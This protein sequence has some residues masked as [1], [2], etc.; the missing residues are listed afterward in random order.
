MLYNSWKIQE[1]FSYTAWTSVLFLV[2]FIFPK[3]LFVIQKGELRHHHLT[4]RIYP[5]HSSCSIWFA[6]Y[7]GWPCPSHLFFL[8]FK[9]IPL[10][11]PRPSSPHQPMLSFYFLKG[12]ILNDT[13]L[14]DCRW[15][16]ISHKARKQ[17]KMKE[18]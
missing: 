8:S 14:Q 18:T 5:D 12:P 17:K 15:Q 16:Y 1:N 13:D 6:L 10:P 7:F 2:Y 9:N 3:R 11:A 4:L